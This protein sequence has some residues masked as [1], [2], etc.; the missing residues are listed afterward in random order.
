M[1]PLAAAAPLIFQGVAAAGAVAG[2][3]ATVDA[4]KA[5]SRANRSQARIAAIQSARARRKSVAEARQVQASNIASASS[6][7]GLEGSSLAGVNASVRSQLT[8]NV[9]FQQQ[10]QSLDQ[11]RFSSLETSI[12]AQANANT[13]NAISGFASSESGQKIASFIKSKA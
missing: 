13:F 4:R 1:G 7:G 3:A 9:S 11:R 10:L 12:N 5:S 6:Q 2:I 8:S